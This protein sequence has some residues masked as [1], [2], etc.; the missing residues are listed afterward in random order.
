MEKRIYHTQSERETEQVGALLAPHL[1]GGDVI[2]FLGSMG[3][4]KTAFVRGLAEG[5]W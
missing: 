4:G 1:K 5:L 3:M 2:A